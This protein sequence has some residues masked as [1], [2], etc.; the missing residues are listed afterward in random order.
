MYTYTKSQGDLFTSLVLD[1]KSK[2]WQVDMSGKRLAHTTWPENVP[3]GL[4]IGP[5]AARAT[6]Y[7]EITA[8]LYLQREEPVQAEFT[9]V[10]KTGTPPLSVQFSDLSSGHPTAWDWTFGDGSSSEK[11]DPGH[12]YTSAGSYDVIL[13]VR[14]SEGSDT[15]KKVNFIVVTQP[16]EP[17]LANFTVSP[18]N[19]MAPLTVQCK[20]KSI[21]N[22]TRINYNFGDGF[23]IAGPDPLHTYKYPGNYTIIQSISKYDA[24]TNSVVNSTMVQQMSSA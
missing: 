24:T 3:I 7:P 14:N 15:L 9:A 2:T 11:Q 8:N 20:D 13:T 17:F 1:T 18:T 4:Q 5:G 6:I 12:T 21:G 10:P 16:P 23:N 22:P 19:G